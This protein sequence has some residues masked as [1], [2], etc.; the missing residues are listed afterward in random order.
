MAAT[1][2]GNY[3]FPDPPESEQKFTRKFGNYFL[4]R[5]VPQL[6]YKPEPEVPDPDRD[7]AAWNAFAEKQNLAS[8]FLTEPLMAQYQIAPDSIIRKDVAT[9]NSVLIR[10]YI[11]EDHSAGYWQNQYFLFQWVFTLLALFVTICAALTTIYSVSPVLAIND[12]TGEITGA[13]NADVTDITAQVAVEPEGENAPASP[14]DALASEANTRE[15]AARI[16]GLLTTVAGATA[17]AFVYIYNRERPR[18]RWYEHRRNAESLRK[19]YFL[20]LMHMPPYDNVRHRFVLETM[21]LRIHEGNANKDSVPANS[22]PRKP[23][24]TRDD[25]DALIRAYYDL[26]LIE[27]MRFYNK[28]AQENDFNLDITMLMT[29]LIP[30]LVTI[31]AAL[32]L[33]APSTFL[34]WLTIILPSFAALFATFQ[35]VYDWETQHATYKSTYAGL[36][37]AK[38][39]DP[40]DPTDTAGEKLKEPRTILLELVDGVERELN[41]EA[42]QWGTAAAENETELSAEQIIEAFKKKAESSEDEIEALRSQLGLN[43]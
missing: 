24:H 35:R 20:Y 2:I 42:D 26:R 6:R 8:S 15:N 18:K 3:S 13:S 12:S 5:R 21:V 4:F 10:T 25:S 19:Q 38:H 37:V 27:Q 36:Q 7:T 29:L 14:Q 1:T 23:E 33:L 43:G 16:F 30:L 11:E 39:I 9:L 17:T 28:R 22:A 40:V 34:G 41:K 32:N 31:L